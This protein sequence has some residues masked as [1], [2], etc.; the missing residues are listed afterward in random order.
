MAEICT[1]HERY[2]IY[3]IKGHYK[4]LIMATSLKKLNNVRFLIV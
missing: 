3:D 4:P 1:G 2:G